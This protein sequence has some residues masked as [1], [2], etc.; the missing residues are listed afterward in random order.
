MRREHATGTPAQ[1][2]AGPVRRREL[3][4]AA[5]GDPGPAWLTD[6]TIDGRVG[7]GHLPTR[8]RAAARDPRALGRR[9]GP[10][11]L[12]TADVVAWQAADP[13][14]GDVPRARRGRQDRPTPSPY[15]SSSTDSSTG[16]CDRWWSCEHRRVARL[17]GPVGSAL[18]A[19]PAPPRV[20]RAVVPAARGSRRAATVRAGL[21]AMAA[22]PENRWPPASPG[23]IRDRCAGPW[24]GLDAALARLAD[25]MRRRPYYDPP[26]DLEPALAEY[27]RSMGGWSSL[28]RTLDVTDSTTRAQFRDH[29]RVATR[30]AQ[31]D[32]AALVAG[33]VLPELTDRRSTTMTDQA[34]AGIGEPTTVER[35]A[36]PQDVLLLRKIDEE[37]LVP[38][39]R[40]PR[41][42]TRSRT[43]RELPDI[44]P[45]SRP[46]TCRRASSAAT[47]CSPPYSSRPSGSRPP[48]SSRRI[49]CACGGD[50]PVDDRRSGAP[51]R[52]LR[53]RPPARAAPVVARWDGEPYPRPTLY[54][55]G[56]G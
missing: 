4:A 38:R 54:A 7:S 35:R 27:V 26:D 43:L 25:T 40:S 53:G 49:R 28:C 30:R 29:W 56:L 6:A 2:R 3:R 10:T 9:V 33:S 36:R 15:P 24:R 47:R 34:L 23:E 37:D 18:A 46:A 50:A 1:H 5:E 39:Q 31:V 8:L 12:A 14:A 42:S 32:R 41:W 44:S 48:R 11:C 22:D 19:A 21:L 20:S 51:D 17:A 52:T 13:R 45:G 55:P 16:P